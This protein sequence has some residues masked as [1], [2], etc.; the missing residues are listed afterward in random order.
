[1]SYSVSHLSKGRGS[2]GILL[3]SIGALGADLDF[4][5]V[6]K[7]TT[8][9]G[10]VMFFKWLASEPPLEHLP[11]VYQV[12]GKSIFMQRYDISKNREITSGL[13]RNIARAIYAV[14]GLSYRTDSNH[15]DDAERNILK[16]GGDSVSAYEQFVDQLESKYGADKG[17][18]VLSHND[19]Y[20]AN[21]GVVGHNH[22]VLLDFGLLAMNYPGADLHH[23]MRRSVEGEG[24]DRLNSIIKEY[25]SIS[26]VG[27]KVLLRN[28]LH[29]MYL[30]YLSRCLFNFKKSGSSEKKIRQENE[31]LKQILEHYSFDNVDNVLYKVQ[32]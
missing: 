16:R 31:Y 24:F 25:I 28:C 3:H 9:K 2:D 10:E 29:Y 12:L 21:I 6:E 27:R 15:F 5:V 23:F 7:V 20:W 30:R 1:L 4:K 19:L 22:P 32:N 13:L 11:R 14:N 8:R 17:I 18:E 26:G